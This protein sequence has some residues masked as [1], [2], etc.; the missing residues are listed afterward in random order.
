MLVPEGHAATGAILSWVT[1]A[2]T[3]T[4][5]RSKAKL[6]LS[7]MSG[8]MVL[9]QSGSVL[10]SLASVTTGVHCNREC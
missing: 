6:Q 5:V 10:K 7:V 2:T 3:R 9:L 4:L 8:S 1:C